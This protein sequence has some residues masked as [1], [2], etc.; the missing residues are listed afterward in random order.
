LLAAYNC[1][2]KSDIP[3]TRKRKN[4]SEQIPA[5]PIAGEGGWT[6]AIGALRVLAASGL[7]SREREKTRENEQKRQ[8]GHAEK[9]TDPRFVQ[10]RARARGCSQGPQKIG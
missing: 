3:G 5:A 8:T 1:Q 2:P 10:K 7:P 4:E 6:T 9:N